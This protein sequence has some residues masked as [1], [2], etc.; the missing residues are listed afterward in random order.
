MNIDAASTVS[1]AKKLI[2]PERNAL[3]DTTIE[4]SKGLFQSIATRDSSDVDST[5]T[6]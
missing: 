3:S 5:W 6:V 4:V 2:T 1:N